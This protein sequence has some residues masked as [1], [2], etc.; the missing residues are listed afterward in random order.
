MPLSRRSRTPA[1]ATA[2]PPQSEGFERT[3]ATNFLGHFLLAQSLL[4]TLKFTSAAA[5]SVGG[6][7]APAVRVVCLGS[8]THR[9][10]ARAPDWPAVIAGSSALRKSQYALSK[11]AAIAFAAELQRRLVGTGVAAVAVNPGAVRS[12]IWRNCSR[13]NLCWL[14]P[15]MR[16]TFLTPEQGS[17]TSVAAATAPDVGGVRLDGASSAHPA[18]GGGGGGAGGVVYLSP[19]AWAPR[20]L[21]AVAGGATCGD[22]LGPFAGPTVHLP[23]PPS[24]DARVGL[25]LWTAC[26]AAVARAHGGL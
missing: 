3:F 8:V 13:A 22:L 6:G 4:D 14:S 20:W 16:L 25:A 18:A 23:T 24:V 26:E 1:T 11:F 21:G 19:Y 12:T 9:L 2:P 5:P 15:L 10:I 7:G 17:A